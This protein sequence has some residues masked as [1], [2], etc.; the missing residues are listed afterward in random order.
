MEVVKYQET[1]YWAD[2]TTMHGLFDSSE[3]ALESLKRNKN[4]SAVES[5]ELSDENGKLIA[6][7]KKGEGVKM[8]EEVKE[9]EV[10]E[11][12][13]EFFKNSG[14]SYFDMYN[15]W[16]ENRNAQLD[17]ALNELNRLELTKGATHFLTGIM[18][19]EMKLVKK[20]KLYRVILDGLHRFEGVETYSKY[21]YLKSDGTLAKTKSFD[22]ITAMP[23]KDMKQLP[24][25]AQALAK[26]VK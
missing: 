15:D 21:V 1:T 16:G 11:E 3:N 7:Y 12:T 22:Y 26:E 24:E 17:N 8:V 2:D 25:W 23:E 19:G 4:Y 5:A 13:Y 9:I 6:T 10:S 18:K 14:K 20:E